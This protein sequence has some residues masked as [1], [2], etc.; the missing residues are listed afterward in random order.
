MEI[1]ADM[2]TKNMNPLCRNGFRLFYVCRQG[3]RR[4]ADMPTTGQH[5]VGVA[6]AMVSGRAVLD[7]NVPAA[8]IIFAI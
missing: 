3:R 5:G 4:G 2:P 6:R 1:R 8:K 7:P